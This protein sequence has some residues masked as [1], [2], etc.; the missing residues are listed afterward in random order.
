MM[1]NNNYPN[2]KEGLKVKTQ[3]YLHLNPFT[4]IY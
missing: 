3:M 1:E 2:F 4:K